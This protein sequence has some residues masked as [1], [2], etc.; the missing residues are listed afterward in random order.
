MKK[1]GFTL[2]ELLAVILILG[3]IA[4][5]AIPTVTSIIEQSKKNVA[6]TSA[7]N[8]AQAIENTVSIN[9]LNSEL[10]DINDGKVYDLST[11]KGEQYSLNLSNDSSVEDGKV[12]LQDG[13]V[14]YYMIQVDDY[15]VEKFKDNTTSTKEK[16]V[17]ADLYINDKKLDVNN[18]AP[19]CLYFGNCENGTET[20]FNPTTADF[21][22]E[23]DY[24]IENSATENANGCMKWYIFNDDKYQS[25]MILDHNTSSTL[26][27]QSNTD[28]GNKLGPKNLFES[29]AE[30]TNNWSDNLLMNWKSSSDAYNGKAGSYGYDSLYI[31]NGSV[32]IKPL[33]STGQTEY[34][35]NNAKA[36]IITAE[37]IA[38]L[39]NYETLTNKSWSKDSTDDGFYLD[40]GDS[41]N[42][43][44]KC[45][46]NGDISEC[47]YGWL[48]DRSYKNCVA[49]GCYNNGEETYYNMYGFWTI[50]ASA[51]AN[52]LSYRITN[53]SRLFT[54]EIDYINRGGI[55][56]VLDIVK[57]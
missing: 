47:K 41:L 24:A 49:G 17:F 25:S 15:C 33:A 27:W 10:T 34:V 18:D 13:L 3:I 22:K 26:V 37:E 16:C 20:Y 11:L 35:I 40:N 54:G 50:T 48:I 43:S 45:T 36:R 55:R 28:Y 21:C 1:N 6:M 14:E 31:S 4:L 29:L 19:I 39:S 38:Q 5:I 8:V 57:K 53:K 32:H 44:N 12:F 2:I 46:F 56:P 42:P 23:S 51:K 52:N 30:D 9:S 7:T